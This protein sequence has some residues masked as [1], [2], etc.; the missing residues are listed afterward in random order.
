[1]GKVLITG[2]TGLIGTEL[3]ALLSQ[4][5]YEIIILSTNKEK[6]DNNRVYYWDYENNVIDERS[7]QDVEYVI[8]L[9][10]TNITSGR[11]TKR[12]KEMI[13]HSR[14]KSLGFLRTYFIRHKIKPKALI[15]ASA[16]GFYGTATSDKIHKEDDA[17]GNDFVSS[18][19]RQWEGEAE[20]FRDL[21]SRV[22]ILRIG[23]VLAG[24][25][26]TLPQLINLTKAGLGTVIGSGKQYIPWIH[27]R[28]LTSIILLALDQHNMNT[29]Y[30]AVAPEHTTNKDF[31]Y[32]L[33]DVLNKRIWLPHVPP[34][35][36]KLVFGEMSSIVLE[37]SRVSCEKIRSERFTFEFNSL[38]KALRNIIVPDKKKR[39][40]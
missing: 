1:M 38:N 6:A 40:A 31:M 39:P 19:C 26:G 33:A 24:S 23:I 20:S 10:G 3:A 29:T 12:R 15:A 21:G 2:G 22:A 28:D 7:L 17:S 35:I 34:F 16:V 32:K 36:M 14:T 13:L 11:W 8:H 9:A 4:N 5:G 18:V 27:I 30:N 25:G 37:G